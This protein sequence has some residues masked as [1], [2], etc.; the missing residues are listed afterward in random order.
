MYKMVAIDLDG[1]LLNSYSEISEENKT[2]LRN[3]MQNGIEVVLASG[4]ILNS[5]L[6]FC[7]E[8]GD[9]NYA[10]SG[11]GSI[12]YDIKNSKVIYDNNMDKEKV[13]QIIKICDENSIYYS[14]YTEDGIIAKD[15]DYNVLVYQ[16]ENLTKNKQK[17][18][19][20]TI[21]QDIC[22]YIN[23]CNLNKFLKISICDGDKAVFSNIMKKLKKIENIDVLDVAHMSKKS[24]K[25]GN[26]TIPV[27]YFYTEITNENVNKWE[28]IKVL[29]EKMSIEKNEVICIGDNVND[30]EMIQNAG[31]GVAMGNSS[32]DIKAIAKAVTADNNCNGVAKIL[33]MQFI[34]T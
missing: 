34:N 12:L 7:I 30:I 29:M 6:N 22:E 1:T 27:E 18:V 10:I 20:I 3:A 19:N 4:R 17:R 15:L 13:M 31:F 14:I 2:A 11:N 32:P 8:I 9:L 16:N 28:A 5:V 23:Y 33:K 24:I 21:V 26:E 25:V